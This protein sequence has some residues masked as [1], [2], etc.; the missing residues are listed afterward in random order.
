VS[1][2]PQLFDRPRIRLRRERA[3]RAGGD[4]F[5]EAEA[6]A[7]LL[8]RLD[9]VRRTFRRALVVGGGPDLARA[10]RRR[11]G[12]AALLLHLDP[13]PARLAPD[14]A[15][16]AV[17][18]EAWLPVAA[19]TFDLVLAGPGLALVDDVPGALA[20]MVRALVPD[21][22]LLA[23]FWGGET[24]V[25]LR[26]AFVEAELALRGGAALRVAPFAD[27]LEA[28]ALLQRLGLALAVADR[29]R[30]RVRYADPWRLL[31]DLRAAGLTGV[32]RA[33]RPLR[34]DVLAAALARYRE[35]F[36]DADGRV[37]AS[38]ELLFLTGWKPHPGQP[39]P[40][41]RGSGRVDLAALLGRP[42]GGGE[43]QISGAAGDAGAGRSKRARMSAQPSNPAP[44]QGERSSQ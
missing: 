32:L 8:D 17:A 44:G 34:R 9:D 21:G 4:F 26:T 7:R 35:A 23:A 22:L 15:R 2:P 42:P 33:R 16:V 6:A 14:A 27:L 20:Q 38:F 30:I 40:R 12:P 39:K 43:D 25:E 5:L 11:L 29:D 24:L 10:L 31:L 28:A 41:P 37:V 19:A 3:A 18:D 36:A 1:P 13:A